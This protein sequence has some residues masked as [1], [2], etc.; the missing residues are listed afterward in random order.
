MAGACDA[1]ERCRQPGAL[2]PVSADAKRGAHAT[3]GTRRRGLPTA[4][5]ARICGGS[6]ISD[7]LG[8]HAARPTSR[9]TSRQQ[10]G[11]PRRHLEA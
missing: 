4:R 3:R 5:Q 1:G 8:M 7:D 9:P 2:F 10:P 11:G 6:A